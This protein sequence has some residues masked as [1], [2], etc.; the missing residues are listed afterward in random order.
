MARAPRV[1][2]HVARAAH[3]DD[4]ARGAGARGRP[5]PVLGT[6]P[7]HDNRAVRIQLE[8]KAQHQLSVGL[9]R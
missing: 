2:E 8:A 6:V 4:G 9:L 1:R 7:T 5:L 3:L